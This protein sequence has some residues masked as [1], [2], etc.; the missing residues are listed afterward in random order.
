M[1]IAC[2]V[3][4][5]WFAVAWGS[6]MG[7]VVGPFRDKSDCEIVRAQTADSGSLMTTCWWDGK[8]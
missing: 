6:P 5:W 7:R 1:K 4:A 8:N 3:L 2:V